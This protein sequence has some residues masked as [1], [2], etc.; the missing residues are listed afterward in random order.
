M[1]NYFNNVYHLIGPKAKEG[2][3]KMANH[4]EREIKVVHE[5][6]EYV[7]LVENYAATPHFPNFPDTIV[8]V[9]SNG[10]DSLMS[11]LACGCDDIFLSGDDEHRISPAR[12]AVRRFVAATDDF[13]GE[14][15]NCGTD[16]VADVIRQEPEAMRAAQNLREQL[17]RLLLGGSLPQLD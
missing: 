9:Q 8:V 3:A 7:R 6:P 4:P 10:D 5:S 17:E 12:A 11:S 2:A 16:A 13:A 15:D 14:V 1:S